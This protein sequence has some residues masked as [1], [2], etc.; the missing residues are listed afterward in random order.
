M[1]AFEL[2]QIHEKSGAT[3]EAARWYTS[4][5]ERFRR[6]QWKQKAE[7]ALTRLGAPIPVALAATP[8]AI[9][10]SETPADSAAQMEPVIAE[11]SEEQV[12]EEGEE[13]DGGQQESVFEQPA[14]GAATA[15]SPQAAEDR[16]GPPPQTPRAPRRARP[17]QR[18][19][20]GRSEWP[21]RRRR[22]LS[23]SAIRVR[24]RRRTPQLPGRSNPCARRIFAASRP[25]TRT[26]PKRRTSRAGSAF[27][28]R[29]RSGDPALSSRMAQL[30]SQLRRMLA[31]AVHSVDQ[32]DEAPAGP[33][34][35]LITDTD[36][37]ATTISK[38]A[39]HCAS[40]SAIC[41]AAGAAAA[42][43]PT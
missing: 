7:E 33:G 21:Q 3:P 12:T 10:E 11:I 40:V 34:V 38:P 42:K 39:R 29:T 20:R 19:A 9:T 41:F 37:T 24:T 35:F 18:R 2:A 6:A 17:E 13:M 4:A 8:A 30:E 14:A 5:A 26:R 1:V 43:A 22:S 28:M 15:T 27:Q 23:C 16:S 36:Q 31:C 32:A 25:G